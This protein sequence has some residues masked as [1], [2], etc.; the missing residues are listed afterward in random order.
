MVRLQQGTQFSSGQSISPG[1]HRHP[2]LAGDQPARILETP[3]CELSQTKLNQS[4]IVVGD[5]Q[6]AAQVQTPFQSLPRLYPFSQ[7]KQH[8]SQLEVRPLMKGLRSREALC[9]FS[10]GYQVTRV[11]R[12]GYFLNLRQSFQHWLRLQDG[13]WSGWSGL[14]SSG[15]P[16]RNFR[17][18]WHCLHLRIRR[19]R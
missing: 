14:G 4:Q 3:A 12:L 11:R 15:K 19:R 18:L 17:L 10:G 6:I 16:I 5:S 2:I 9:K 1:E 7:L 13:L 8:Q